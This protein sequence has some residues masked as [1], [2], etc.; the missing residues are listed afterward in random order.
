LGPG[1]GGFQWD[2]NFLHR[3]SKKEKEKAQIVNVIKI[4]PVAAELLHV[5]GRTGEGY[6]EANSRFSPF[7]KSPLK[8][9]NNNYHHLL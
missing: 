8:P 5:D 3:F 1:G 4:C 7:C 9:V 6:D 2:L